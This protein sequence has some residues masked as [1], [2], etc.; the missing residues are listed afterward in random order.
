MNHSPQDLVIL[1]IAA[2]AES[3]TGTTIMEDVQQISLVQ[4]L[5]TSVDILQPSTDLTLITN[6]DLVIV[7]PDPIF[8]HPNETEKPMQL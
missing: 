7:D 6:P 4:T 8:I 3:T 1:A 5:I 2:L